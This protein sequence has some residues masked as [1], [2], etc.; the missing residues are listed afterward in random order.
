MRRFSKSIAVMALIVSSAWGV[1]QIGAQVESKPARTD[2][3]GFLARAGA[4]QFEVFFYNTG[5]RVF[6]KDNAGTPVDASRLGGTVTFFH[7]NSQQPWFS[8]PLSPAAAS[9]GERSPSL[10]LAIGL[11]NAPHSG[12]SASFEITGLSESAGGKVSFTLPVDFVR[13][14]SQTSVASVPRYTYGPGSQGYGY[15]EY[16]S[17]GTYTTPSGRSSYMSSIPGMFGPGGMTVG[18]GHRDWTTGRPS[19][20][21]RPWLRPMD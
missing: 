3:G 9:P 10:D 21:A 18:P 1:G 14:P 4:H 8:R 20:L 11:T 2:R 15:Y 19:P 5:V 16:T 7:P 12:A 13:A 17:P 6:A